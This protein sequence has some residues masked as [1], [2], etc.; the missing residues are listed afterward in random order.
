MTGRPFETNEP[1]PAYIPFEPDHTHGVNERSNEPY[2]EL[3]STPPL[4]DSGIYPQ[5]ISPDIRE[6]DKIAHDKS[7][8]PQEA[9]WAAAFETY[10]CPQA[11]A[12]RV[13][14][15]FQDLHYEKHVRFTNFFDAPADG[16]EKLLALQTVTTEGAYDIV[17]G[18]DQTVTITCTTVD[19]AGNK[20]TTSQGYYRD[21]QDGY[22]LRAD[23]SGYIAMSDID[24]N[25]VLRCNIELGDRVVGQEEWNR[26][27]SVLREAE[28]PQVTFN[29]LW[30]SV[31]E[32]AAS[33]EPPH[34]NNS[35]YGAS[36]LNSY[37]NARIAAIVKQLPPDARKYFMEKAEDCDVLTRAA[38][39]DPL[40]FN[41]DVRYMIIPGPFITGTGMHGAS[42]MLIHTYVINANGEI[43]QSI[44]DVDGQCTEILHVFS[45]DDSW[46]QCD[47]STYTERRTDTEAGAQKIRPTLGTPDLARKVRNFIH[48]L[49]LPEPE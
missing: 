10:D 26:I 30:E 46:L 19:D 20:T 1:D 25:D 41:D 45:Q 16:T 9:S 2:H 32:L 43:A 48:Q 35:L 39:D 18:I 28:P 13:T 40:F 31:Q 29:E 42:V 6:S 33:D 44:A 47:T 24:K 23:R 12:V 37:V 5:D 27:E 8:G 11:E 49:P 3:D 14:E 15:S 4:H 7:G 36:E 38:G 21:S 22:L 34:F 17:L